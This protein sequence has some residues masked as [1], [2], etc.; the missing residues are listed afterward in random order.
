LIIV[1]GLHW[2][3]ARFLLFCFDINGRPAAVMTA[4]RAGP[5]RKH[6]FAA[7]RTFIQSIG[8]YRMMRSFSPGRPMRP[9]FHWY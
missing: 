8:F 5:V 7:L 4:K 1:R 2:L 6:G 3:L 9:S